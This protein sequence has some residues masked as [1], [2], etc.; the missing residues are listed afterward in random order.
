M[1]IGDIKLEAIRLMFVNY[2]A[3]ISI[4]QIERLKADENYNSYLVNMP[5]S[6]NR[7]LSDIEDKRVLPV[8]AFA[9]DENKQL[10]SAAIRRFNLLEL[11][12]DFFDVERLVCETSN[13]EYIGDCSYQREGN[14]LV[15]FDFDK[16]NNYTVLYYPSI[17]RI[18][19]ITSD[20]LDLTTAVKEGCTPIKIPENITALIPYF[21]KGDLYREDEPNEA[22]E[23]RNWYES[24]ME[25]IYQ[26]IINKA[27]N[28]VG[29][30][31]QT[32]L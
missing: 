1:K 31:M 26:G 22:S 8:K 3:D 19:S 9:L 5:G 12:P 16:D 28:V 2:N 23:A 6:I 18:T 11:I 7:C 32:R 14:T 25:K 24:G 13:G 15:I 4:D 29:V 20:D 10:A 27:N 21:I 17:E 30:F